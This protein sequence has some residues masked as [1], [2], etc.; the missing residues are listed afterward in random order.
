MKN[1]EA[2]AV[3]AVLAFW[4]RLYSALATDTE[5]RVREAAHLAHLEVA[6]KV[7]RNLAPYLKQVIG[8]WFTAQYDSYPPAATA[9]TQAFEVQIKFFIVKL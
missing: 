4:P 1:S 7:K 3:K 2:E 8:P 9:A 6:L 5:H